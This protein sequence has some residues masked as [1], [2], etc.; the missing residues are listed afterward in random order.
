MIKQ[1]KKVSWLEVQKNSIRKIA[2]IISEE[3]GFSTN[4]LNVNCNVVR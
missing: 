4:L 1:V 2:A 3:K